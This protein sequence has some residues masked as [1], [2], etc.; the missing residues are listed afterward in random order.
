M[1][2]LTRKQQLFVDE[3]LIDLN[4]TQAAIRAGYSKKTAQEQASRLLSNVMVQAA[5]SEAMQKREKRTEIT[6]DRVLVELAKIGFAS[7]TDYL[8]YR[9]ATR[10]VGNDNDGEPIYDWAMIV[11]ATESGLVDGAPIQEVSVGKDGTF[12]FKLY[13][14]LDALGK[15][16]K[17]LGMFERREG[18]DVEDLS[19]A[20]QEVFGDDKNA[21]A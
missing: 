21:D 8:S 6:Q 4:A 17:H 9:T 19:E 13:S 5:I 15:I 3:Y 7:I 10:Q 16:G 1:A 2:K 20:R 12:K 11:D 14:K 18:F